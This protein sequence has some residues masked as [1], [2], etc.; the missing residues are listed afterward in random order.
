MKHY[1]DERSQQ[2][3]LA[4]LKAHGIRKVVASPGTT[5]V[6]L[7]GSMQ[8]DPWFEMYSCADERSAAYL[9]VGLAEESGEAVVLTCTGA[10]ASRNYLPGLTEAYY[11]K[12]PVLAITANQG[13]EKVGNLVAQN[14][15]R[16]SVPNDVVKLS[17]N[18]PVCKDKDDEWNVN[19]SVNKALLELRRNGGGPVHMDL[20]TAYS[21]DFSVKDLPSERVIGRYAVTDELPPMP[22]G[23]RTVV[24]VGSH[25][26]WSDSQVRA[27]DSFCASN[28]A[29]VLCDHTSG[30]NGKYKVGFSLVA[31]QDSYKSELLK[32]GLLIHVG[33]VSGDYYTM[34]IRPDKVWRVSPD[35]EV[36]D[37]FRRLT[38]VFEM[39]EEF[40]F[41]HYSAASC[42][43]DPLLDMYRK[44]CAKV[45]AA[46]P[47]LPFSNIW[48]AKTA[49]RMIPSGS[50]LHFGILNS[51]RAWNF[52][53]LPA[54]VETCA[55]VGGFGIDGII[56]SIVGAAIAAPDK[57][58]FGILGDLAFFYDMNVLGNRH[59]PSNVRIMMVNN[60]KGTEFRNYGHVCHQWGDEADGYM[61]AAGHYGSRSSELVR[62]YAEDLGYGYM[63]ASSKEEFNDRIER[64]LD[65]NAFD[66]P[67][68]LEV[69][70]ESEL[71]SKALEMTL[72][73]FVDK[74]HVVKKQIRGAMADA[75]GEG[76]VRK[77]E[78]LLK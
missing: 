2:I 56:S 62:H 46:L 69:F 50:V 24:F 7:V 72:N 3:V 17:V 41:S 38:K 58:F 55:N 67:V 73:A 32:V 47:E 5:N 22:E 4:L 27:L 35:G 66:R 14:V 12:L 11:R 42:K 40:F 59:V 51:L 30:Y 25:S 45:H 29:V 49:S 57:M 36:R 61:A 20:A 8:N 13:R 34:R 70:T 78:G 18:L 64:F 60:G 75:L 6:T 37:T 63:C 1:T 52:F 53:D 33:E 21:T 10:T 16:S 15:D 28:D 76:V 77:I 43:S 44:E 74:S 31:G 23:R 68:I 48:M 54:S 65:K 71:E 9:A 19:L 39:P 26:R